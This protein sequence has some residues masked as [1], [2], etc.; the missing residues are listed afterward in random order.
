MFLGR[1][2]ERLTDSVRWRLFPHHGGEAAG[3]LTFH[4]EGW[5]ESHA[6]S[7]PRQSSPWPVAQGQNRSLLWRSSVHVTSA[8]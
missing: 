4:G 1:T 8:K 3:C 7:V 5:T 6:M 2:R